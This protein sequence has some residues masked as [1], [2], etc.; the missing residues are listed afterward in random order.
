M[1]VAFRVDA[2]PVIGTGHLYRCLTLAHLLASRGESPI[3]VVRHIP[4]SLV[5]DVADAGFECIRLAKTGA[6]ESRASWCS[7][8]EWLE[9]NWLD[10]AAATREALEGKDCDWLV[11]DHYAL[12]IQWQSAVRD[13]CENFMVIDDL[14]DRKHLCDVLLD[15]NYLQDSFSRYQTLV[16]GSCECLLGPEY[17]LLRPEF[18]QA[19]ESTQPREGAISR[20]LVFMGGVDSD[21]MTTVILKGIELLDAR[22]ITVD[23]VVGSANPHRHEVEM[24]T[25]RLRGSRLFGRLESLAPLMCAS[26]LAIGAA[27]TTTWERCCLGLP[28]LTMAIADN[29]IPIAEGSQLG[30]FA[31]N[32]G[33][34]E[35]VTPELIA[36][37]IEHLLNNP[38]IV[39]QM[40]LAGMR[41]VDGRG[42]ER[43]ADALVNA[44]AGLMRGA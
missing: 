27:G 22:T 16:P 3:F 37:G 26:D 33:K 34:S 18:S 38:V 28:T 40:S 11:V 24:L 7:H 1:A 5:S 39:H 32:L 13:V 2:S 36:R 9:A 12:D 8:A 21:N 35:W 19:R 14:A 41:L 17:A 42:A 31:V 20:I 15:Q 4:D 44:T 10:D 25:R 30:G 23:V 29:Q 6:S 43:V